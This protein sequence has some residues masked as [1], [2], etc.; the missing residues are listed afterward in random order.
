MASLDLGESFSLSAS[1]ANV[2]MREEVNYMEKMMYNVH[3]A[4]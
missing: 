4:N 2:M 1:F 3:V